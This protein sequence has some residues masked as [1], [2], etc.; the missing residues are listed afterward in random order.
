MSR[1]RAIESA[2]VMAA[3]RAVV[4]GENAL[5]VKCEDHL[6]KHFLGPK[7]RIMGSI[8]PQRLL[9]WIIHLKSPGGY[10]FIIT[11]TRHFD[12]TLLSE[13]RSGV[14]QV[15]L[16]GAGYDSRPFRFQEEL[17]Q[18]KV[19]EIDH[20]GTQGRKKR[21]LK[22]IG[23]DSPANLRYLPIDF[24]RNSL[25]TALLEH[26]FSRKKKTLFLWEGV[27]YYLPHPA[28]KSVLD[29]VGTCARGSSIVFDYA[30]RDFVEKDTSTY[31]GKPIASWLKKIREPFLF[32]L[33][34]NETQQFLARHELHTVSDLGPEDLE[35]R[36]L[37]TKDGGLLGR[38]LG[39][40]R[41][42]HARAIGAQRARA[43]HG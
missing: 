4:A 41:M 40:L 38:T 17:R 36:H 11:R 1:Y 26:G 28:V 35:V 37:K 14:E 19:F 32:G 12:E 13:I 18:V 15:V 7:Y 43:E 33:N 6:A 16:L 23:L 8:L 31:G 29:F 39:H 2:E 10:Y 27:S 24:N 3:V 42:V 5:A 21:L 30:I 34:A 9:R 20:P 22:R 25:Q